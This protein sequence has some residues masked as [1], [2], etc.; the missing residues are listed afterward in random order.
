MELIRYKYG[1]EMP[2][3]LLSCGVAGVMGRSLLFT[4]PGS[5]KAVNEYIE[6]IIKILMHAIYMIHGLDLH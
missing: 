1:S 3:S 4:L 2:G 5:L 6:E